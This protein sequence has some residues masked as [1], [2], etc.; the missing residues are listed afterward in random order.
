MALPT[1]GKSEGRP[2]FVAGSFFALSQKLFLQTNLNKSPQEKTKNK[3]TSQPPKTQTPYI[4]EEPRL[5]SLTSLRLSAASFHELLRFQVRS[6]DLDSPPG[7]L[8]QR[9]QVPPEAGVWGV[10]RYLLRRYLA[11]LGQPIVFSQLQY[12][13]P[14]WPWLIGGKPSNMIRQCES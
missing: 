3:P 11:F 7:D 12:F 4:P 10:K 13:E 8:T 2:P 9:L 6:W 14:N 1:V 5:T